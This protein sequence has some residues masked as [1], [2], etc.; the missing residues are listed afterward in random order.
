MHTTTHNTTR[1]SEKRN[2]NLLCIPQVYQIVVMRS[3]SYDSRCVSIERR[4]SDFERFH[5]QLL[6]KFSEELEDVHFP[7]K[8]LSRN[9][10]PEMIAERRLA[11]QDYLAQIYAIRC[12]RYSQHLPEFF[13]G[14]E[15][16]RAHGLLRA[17]QF[18]AATEQLQTTLDLL[19]KLVPWQSP[20][21]LVPTLCALAV[22][23]RDLE[24]L[25]D[26]FAMA[27]R[28]LPAVRRYK[29][30]QYRAPLLELLVD[31]GYLLHRPVAQLQEELS[32]F[33]DSERGPVSS[34]SLKELVVR[35][36]T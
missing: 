32:L 12:I 31:V 36:F 35:K 14:Q 15:Q 9:F 22:G 23:H 6:E 26:A 19:E 28:A 17:G 34:G 7:R 10:N 18:K 2:V 25:E 29:L 1:Y 3:G 5:Q 13:T 21:L 33:R 4:Y 8:H 27:H 30:C 24:E 20:T 16:I 11:F